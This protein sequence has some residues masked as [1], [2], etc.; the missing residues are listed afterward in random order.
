MKFYADFDFNDENRGHQSRNM[1][2]LADCDRIATGLTLFL[3]CLLGFFLSL[4]V[5]YPTLLPEAHVSSV[6][7]ASHGARNFFSLHSCIFALFV[8]WE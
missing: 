1:V 6:V 8:S 7:Q 2:M 4:I 3:L 5:R